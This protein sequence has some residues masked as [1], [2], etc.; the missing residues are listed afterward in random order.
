M[1]LRLLDNYSTCSFSIYLQNTSVRHQR[2]APTR[3]QRAACKKRDF[4]PHSHACA[5]TAHRFPPTFVPMRDPNVQTTSHAC[6][7]LHHPIS[8]TFPRRSAHNHVS[9]I[10]HLEHGSHSLLFFL[11]SLSSPLR[12]CY[13]PFYVRAFRAKMGIE[14]VISTALLRMLRCGRREWQ[15]ARS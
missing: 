10:P 8:L 14:G 13:R 12:S 5:A 2:V 1:L 11:R 3:G 4:L 7:S 15:R 9:T 6:T